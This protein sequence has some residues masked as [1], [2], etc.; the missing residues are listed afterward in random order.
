M[1]NLTNLTSIQ[2][3]EL[4]QKYIE[5]QVDG[6]DHKDMYHFVYNVLAEDFD[7]LSDLEL[8]DE[9]RYT[10]DDETFDDLIESVSNETVLDTNNTGGKY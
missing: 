4:I 3:D 1:A 7:K 9:I 5:L 8:E 6:M 2:K 10:F